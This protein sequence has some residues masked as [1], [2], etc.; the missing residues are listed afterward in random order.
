MK[1]DEYMDSLLEQI[2]NDDAKILIYE[3]IENHIEE[4]KRHIC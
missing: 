4:Q 1:Y 2:E 3:E